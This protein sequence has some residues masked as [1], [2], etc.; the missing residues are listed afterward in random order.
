MNERRYLGIALVA[1]AVVLGAALLGKSF[2]RGSAVRIAIAVVQAF[3]TGIVVVIPIRDIRRLDEMQQRI[4]L[5]AL[6]FSFA[7][8]GILTTAYGFLVSAGLPDI[9]WG[10]LVWPLMVG[11]WAAGNVVAGRRYRG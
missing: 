2:E 3:A 11:L 9:E 5:E 8:T 1:A 4:Q 7:G 6:A 10:A